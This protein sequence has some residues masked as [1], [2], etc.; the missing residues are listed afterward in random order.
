MKYARGHLRA[1]E[2]LRQEYRMVSKDGFFKDRALRRVGGIAA[3]ALIWSAGAAIPGTVSVPKAA[4]KSPA[5]AVVR[6]VTTPAE[7][8]TALEKQF[9]LAL[10]KGVKAHDPALARKLRAEGAH[11]CD[12]GRHA[13]GALRLA[14][15]LADLGLEPQEP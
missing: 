4:P 13:A 15:A 3:A 11:L 5:P 9:D 7:R 1:M 6:G 8:C 2:S 10:L 12:T 14:K